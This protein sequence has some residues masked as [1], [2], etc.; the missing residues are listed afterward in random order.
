MKKN[1]RHILY[2][3]MALGVTLTTAV[4]LEGSANADTTTEPNQA[5]QT[6]QAAQPTTTPVNTAT[7]DKQQS[8]NTDVLDQ[9]EAQKQAQYQQRY[10]TLYEEARKANHGATGMPLFSSN[11]PGYFTEKPTK[12]FSPALSQKL[13]E[14]NDVRNAVIT[15]DTNS[16][17]NT[18]TDTFDHALS[19]IS[20]FSY[21]NDTNSTLL[22]N[23]KYELPL[24]TD[25][26]SVPQDDQFYIDWLDHEVKLLQGEPETYQVPAEYT[27][28][29]KRLNYI[30]DNYGSDDALLDGTT[31]VSHLYGLPGFN[32]WDFNTNHMV[33]LLPYPGNSEYDVKFYTP[34]LTALINTW[35]E[36]RTQLQKE[37]AA[38]NGQAKTDQM[39]TPQQTPAENTNQQP[40][41]EDS[42]TT[43]SSIV[44]R[45]QT[46]ANSQK[47]VQTA[48]PVKAA[49]SNEKPAQQTEP[50]TVKT[51]T[52]TPVAVSTNT[53][54]LPQTG[55]DNKAMIASIGL[56]LSTLAMMFG[57]AR[58]RQY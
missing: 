27:N 47:T 43:D 53:S 26:K 41:Q 29:I 9:A 46:V 2:T 55:N 51:V 7:N 6:V 57:F 40:K 56:G 4:M 14:A 39:E 54:S 17:L 20:N 38:K 49:V 23:K 19:M 3:S 31:E 34:Y 37:Y 36:Q 24:R 28:L 21:Q 8:T 18:K 5:Q 12:Q 15:K 10:E 11:Q 32:E 44:T 52:T 50:M 58:K 33:H 48:L 45:P 22:P 35:E 1:I 30:A 13:Y 25:V 16:L 42:T